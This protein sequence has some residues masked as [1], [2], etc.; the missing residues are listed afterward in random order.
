MLCVDEFPMTAWRYHLDLRV[1]GTDRH[2]LVDALEAE[3]LNLFRDLPRA[4]AYAAIR[5]GRLRYDATRA[6][7]APEFPNDL[8]VLSLYLF[9]IVRG[10]EVAERY[11]A[12]NVT[13][14]VRAW[15][16]LA[17]R[18]EW[19]K[20]PLVVAPDAEGQFE[21]D[22]DRDDL[23]VVRARWHT[24]PTWFHDGMRRKHPSLRAL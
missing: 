10:V 5:A 12:D 9:A 19:V 2:N 18:G 23:E 4:D 24:Y 1:E 6:E 7:P 15:K 13:D 11:V 22:P 3:D 8:S 21:V 16:V 20:L 14:D 17:R